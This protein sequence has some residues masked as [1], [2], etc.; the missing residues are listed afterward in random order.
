MRRYTVVLLLIVVLLGTMLVPVHAQDEFTPDQQAA[1]DEVRAALEHLASVDTYTA[2]VLQQ[3]D[4]T[5]TVSYEG[6]TLEL[7]QQIKSEGEVAVEYQPDN[8]Y[9]NQ[10]TDLVQDITQ[11]ISGIGQDQETEVG[12]MEFHL[13][14]LDDRIYMQMQVPPDLAGMM[15]EGW[16]DV[17]GGADMFPGMGMF[18]IE[19]LLDLGS[20]FTQSYVDGLLAS[21]VSIETLE[22]EAEGENRYRLDLDGRTLLD[23]VGIDSLSQMFNTEEM[24]FDVPGLIDLMFSDEDTRFSLEITVNASDQTLI[25]YAERNTIDIAITADLIT[26]PTLQG[27]DMSLQQEQL[28]VLIP[29]QFNEPL[30]ITAPELAD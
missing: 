27:A 3:M 30:A 23:T 24:P 18:N 25:E 13:I 2:A 10:Q 19:G 8:Q 21:V 16:Q 6:E 11:T 12:P 28:K 7:I 1:L 20:N 22:S 14:V 17:T 5:V 4:Q 29:C 15:P 26:D 9:D